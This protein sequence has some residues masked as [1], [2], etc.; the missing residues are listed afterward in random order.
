MHT[1]LKCDELFLHSRQGPIAS[2]RHLTTEKNIPINLS[3]APPPADESSETSGFKSGP[4]TTCSAS[5][6]DHFN[7]LANEWWKPYGE[8]G[9]LH[10]LNKLRVPLICDGLTEMGLA[11]HPHSLGPRPLQNLR[12]L[13]VGC[14][15]G[16]LSEALARLGASVTGLDAAAEVIQAAQVHADQDAKIRDRISYVCGSLEDHILGLEQPYDA[17]IAS[18]VVEHVSSVPA[19]LSA[20]NAALRPGG[21]L[22]ITTVNRT[23]MSFLFAIV[24]AEWVLRI[25]PRGTHE[26]NKFVPP[27]EVQANFAASGLRTHL[28]HGMIY[29][30]PTNTWHW[31]RDTAVSYALH[32]VKAPAT[33]TT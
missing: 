3:S 29:F 27:E 17:V 9:P 6:L 19:F 14:G 11:T 26:W 32:A 20:C 7:A 25:V 16:I 21:S 5:E 23:V 10:S 24:M 8:L 4:N 15:G 28:L 22:F 18:E 13:D 33:A 12:L 31:S 1:L 2:L 30:P